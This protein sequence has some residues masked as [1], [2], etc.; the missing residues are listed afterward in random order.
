MTLVTT[1][2]VAGV[3]QIAR[4][5]VNEHRLQNWRYVATPEQ[6]LG[7][8]GDVPILVDGRSLADH[9]HHLAFLN[10]LKSGR[11]SNVTFLS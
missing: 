7:L 3:Y 8:S 5:I 1:Y 4:A 11:F 6:L 10:V 9:P 2:I